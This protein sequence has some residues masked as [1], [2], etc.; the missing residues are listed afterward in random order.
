VASVRQ[1]VGAR[2]KLVASGGIRTG[3]DIVKAMALGADL[4]GMALPL[5]KAQQE[6]G[7]A[8]A[9]Q[10]LKAVLLGIAQ[11]LLLTGSRNAGELR[12]QPKVIMG[13]LKDWL[14]AL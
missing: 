10:A 2:V 3:L 5:F 8:G 14:Q 13:E 7:R 11:G 4:G 12:K 1:A 6:G 9:E